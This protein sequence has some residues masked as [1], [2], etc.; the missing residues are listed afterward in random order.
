VSPRKTLGVGNLSLPALASILNVKDYGAV[1]DGVADDTA[2]INAAI[3]AATALS[4]GAMVLV[5]AGT[6][7]STG[8]V[9][10]DNVWLR[11]CGMNGVTTIKL[12]NSANAHLVTLATIN[13]QNTILSDMELEGNSSNQASTVDNVNYDTTATVSDRHNQ[14]FNVWSQHAKGNGITYVAGRGESRITNVF[15]YFNNVYGFSISTPDL[16]LTGCDAGQNGKQGFNITVGNIHLVN[17]KSWFSGRLDT[18]NGDGYLLSTSSRSTLAGC[19]AQD[20]AT[21]G[22]YFLNSQN[23]SAAG[24]NADSN[25]TGATAAGVKL[26]GVNYTQICGTTGD[27]NGS[28]LQAYGVQFANTNTNNDVC[29]TSRNNLTSDTN[30]TIAATNRVAINGTSLAPDGLAATPGYGFANEVTTGMFRRGAGLLDF[31]AGGTDSLSVT[32]S[33][34]LL[35]SGTKFTWTSGSISGGTQDLFLRRRGAGNLTLGTT[36]VNGVPVA[37]TLSVQNAIT[38]SNLAAANATIDLGLGTGTGLTGTLVVRGGDS[39][40]A[41]G[42][43]AQTNIIRTVTNATKALTTGAATTLVSI[44]LATLQMTGGHIDV[45]MEA[46]DGTN[47]AT[48]SETIYYTAENSAGVFVTNTSVVGTGSTACTATKT[49]TATYALTGANPALLQVTPT[50]TGITATRFTC[51]YNVSHFGNTQPTV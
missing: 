15:S 25:G 19:E 40:V 28:P 47:Q 23:I 51:I 34:L 32:S 6:Y 2:A 30:G 18:A 4:T 42:T 33:L 36:D 5:P 11:G 46:T 1:G 24:I 21:N 29:L 37:Q 22:F 44:P 45:Y 50:L 3:T 41:S 7:L 10:K 43:T 20:N 35:P 13:T 38:G 9:M 31:S 27:R 26:D 16:H 39:S 49:L 17:C 12:K 48:R 8:V 14:I